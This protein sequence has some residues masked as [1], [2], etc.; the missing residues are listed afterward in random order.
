M[1]YD[2]MIAKLIT[3][4]P[5]RDEAIDE[6]GRGARRVPARRVSRQYRFPVGADAASALPRRRADD[7]L[8]R[9]GISGRLQ[10]RAGRREIAAPTS[11]HR[12]RRS[13]L[14]IPCRRGGQSGWRRGTPVRPIARR[15]A[16]RASRWSAR[17]SRPARRGRPS[18]RS[19][20]GAPSKPFGIFL[21]DEAGGQ[22]AGAEPR[23]LEQRREEIDIVRHAVDL[24]RVERLD[25]ASIAS[26]RVG[27]QLI[28]LA[29][30]GS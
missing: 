28:S 23:M 3:W 18:N 4:A 1:F 17:R 7:R 26:S 9:R 21:G 5:T 13:S 25:R 14:D 16:R 30:I 2:P 8:H 24:E 6:A 29:I 27:A 12:R 20:A 15:S 10:R 11:P 19:S 22:L